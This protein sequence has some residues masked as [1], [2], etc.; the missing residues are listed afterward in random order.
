ML[1][2]KYEKGRLTSRFLASDNNYEFLL[3]RPRGLGLGLHELNKGNIIIL[4][5]GTGLY[6]FSDLIDLVFKE[7]LIMEKHPLSPKITS[8]DPVTSQ[9]TLI[10]K[11][12]F[13]IYSA[14]ESL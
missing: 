10:N 13:T 5:G 9:T 3:S 14:V 11:F 1:M 6:P 2:K 8:L 12:A 4:S 7:L